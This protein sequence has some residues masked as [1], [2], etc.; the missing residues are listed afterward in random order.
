MEVDDEQGE[1]NLRRRTTPREDE[2]DQ[3]ENDEERRGGGGSDE[4]DD[5]EGRDEDEGEDHT[6]EKGAG[7]KKRKEPNPHEGRLKFRNYVPRDHLL[8]ELRIEAAALPSMVG[9]INR[10]LIMMEGRRGEDLL[11]LA[12]KKPN[13]D[14][15]RDIERKLDA[16]EKRTQ[17]AIVLLLKQKLEGDEGAS[18]EGAAA[19][20]HMM[21]E[22]KQEQGLSHID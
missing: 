11:A 15:K 14:L 17:R 7:K 12:P 21:I 6:G 3:N 20:E 22:A 13:W 1:H 19:S 16:L 4:D 5:D 2:G 18:I 9:E 8:R 10:K